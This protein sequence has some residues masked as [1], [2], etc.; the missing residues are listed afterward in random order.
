MKEISLEQA[1]K[2]NFKS[3]QKKY[4]GSLTIWNGELKS[5]HRDCIK[6]KYPHIIRSLTGVKDTLKGELF[7]EGGRVFDLVRL[8]NL[9][10]VKFCVFEAN[11]NNDLNYVKDILKNRF[12]EFIV[13]PREFNSVEEGWSA[14]LKEDLEGL[15]CKRGKFEAK[16]KSWKEAV[17][18]IIGYEAGSQKGAFLLTNGKLSGTSAMWVDKYKKARV[19][20]KRVFAEIQYLYKTDSDKCFQPRLKRLVIE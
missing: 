6:L 3:I 4:D 12:N 15:V 18:E 2:M 9:S 7:V 1:R 17:V 5:D 19:E 16:I 8:E 10:K 14:V 13:L 20:G 11:G